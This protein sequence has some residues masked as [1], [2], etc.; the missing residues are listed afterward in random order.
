MENVWSQVLLSFLRRK[1][2]TECRKCWTLFFF[3]HETIFPIPMQYFQFPRRNFSSTLS[4]IFERSQLQWKT[5]KL[6]L[7]WFSQE[8]YIEMCIRKPLKHYFFHHKYWE[9]GRPTLKYLAWSRAQRCASSQSRGTLHV[10]ELSYACLIFTEI[11]LEL[12]SSFLKNSCRKRGI[13]SL[14]SQ[15]IISHPFFLS[16]DCSHWYIMFHHRTRF[17]TTTTTKNTALVL[18]EKGLLT[19]LWPSLWS[20]AFLLWVMSSYKVKLSS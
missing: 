3:F 2:N 1:C 10:Y 9:N 12:I 4:V 11:G 16:Q 17:C 8:I 7:S 5:C 20:H 6:S 18:H 14:C 13:R 19:L 15:W